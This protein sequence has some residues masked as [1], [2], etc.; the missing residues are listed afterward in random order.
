MHAELVELLA[1]RPGER[2][3]DVAT[4]TGGVALAAARSGAAVTG[5]DITPALLERA[6]A[7]AAAAGLEV[8]LVEGTADELPFEDAA[9]DI[10]S[11]CFGVIFAPDRFAAAR[12]LGRVCRPGG[13]LGLTTWPPD[14]GFHALRKRFGA[15]PL[16]GDQDAWG[17]EDSL[18]AMLGDAFDLE[19]EARTLR[20]ESESL[21]ALYEWVTTAVPP[22]VAFMRRLDPARYDEF[23]EFFV[24]QTAKDVQPDGRVVQEREYLLVL[25]RRR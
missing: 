8:A 13:R 12:E 17:D 4:G 11:S 24:E 5:L 22:M 2:W 20:T 15:K 21:E 16:A 18:R 1:P 9:F 3:L 7:D 6:A 10:V 19:V 25:G 23:R 14:Q